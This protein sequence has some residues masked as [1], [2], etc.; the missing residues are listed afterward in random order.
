MVGPTTVHEERLRSR[1]HFVPAASKLLNEL[2]KLSICAAHWIGYKWNAKYSED[3]SELRPFVPKTSS[4]PLDMSLPRPAW[5]GLNRFCTD[6]EKFQSPMPKW[7]FA[8]TSI[9][10]CGA[11][12]QTAAHVILK[13]PRHRAARGYHGLMVLDDET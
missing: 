13:R 12:D 2:S 9:C 10:E 7:G 8:S 1:H 4:R 11:L 5:V 3:Q 6:V